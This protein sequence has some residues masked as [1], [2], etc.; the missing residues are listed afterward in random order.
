MMGRTTASV[1][2][3]KMLGLTRTRGELKWAYAK[4][5]F[6]KDNP[7]ISAVAIAERLGRAPGAGRAMR[8]KSGLLRMQEKTVG[9][10]GA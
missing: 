7:H 3:Q 2:R 6:I 4:V 1:H 8:F 10:E 5:R 9:R